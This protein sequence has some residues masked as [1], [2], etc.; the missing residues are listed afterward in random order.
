MHAQGLDWV[1]EMVKLA[2][3]P[4]LPPDKDIP[5]I[6][7]YEEL[8]GM[9]KASW[10]VLEAALVAT[11]RCSLLACTIYHSRTAWCNI[12]RETT[13]IVNVIPCGRFA[14]AAD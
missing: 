7:F 10:L 8:D 4:A 14:G 5:R 6:L 13:L 2:V 1:W 11:D 3:A 9:D 12:Q